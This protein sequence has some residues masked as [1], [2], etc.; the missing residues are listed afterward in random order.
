MQSES[1][2]EQK[3]FDLTY[4]TKKNFDLTIISLASTKTEITYRL[5]F[6]LDF[7]LLVRKIN[8]RCD[9]DNDDKEDI[10]INTVTRDITYFKIHYSSGKIRQVKLQQIQKA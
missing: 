4:L 10:N 2:A 1:K 3:N 5:M 7:V 6:V 9:D 8:F